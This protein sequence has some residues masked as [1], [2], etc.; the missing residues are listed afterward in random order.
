MFGIIT[1]R[2]GSKG[3]PGKNKKLLLGKPLVEWTFIAASCSVALDKVFLFSDD[4]DIV[5]LSHNYPK[6][7]VIHR[8]DNLSGD[9]TSHFEVMKYIIDQIGSDMKHFVI[10]QPTSPQRT[11][12][13]IDLCV[14]QYHK[15]RLDG[16][17]TY[18]KTDI[19]VE[20]LYNIIADNEGGV[21]IC[22]VK[23]KSTTSRQR[24]DYVYK[25]D[26]AI[27]IQSVKSFITNYGNMPSVSSLNIPSV[28]PYINSSK[29][30]DIDTQDDFD[31]ARDIM[32]SRFPKLPFMIGDREIGSKPFVIVEIGINHE[33][34][35]DKAIKMIDDACDAGAEC[36]KFQCHVIDDEMAGDAKNVIPGNA[37]V[38]IHDIMSR[39]AFNKD[40]ERELME[41]TESKGAI[42]MSTP[43]SRAAANRLESMGVKAY[44]IGSGECNNYPLIEHI[45]KFG[46]PIIISTGMNDISSI[47]PAIDIL[48]KYK[49]PFVINQCTSMYPTPYDMVKLNG[50]KD[51]EYQYPDAHLGLSCHSIGIWSCIGAVPFGATVFEKHFTSDKKWEGPDVPISINPE[52]LS[53]LLVGLDA[54]SK[55]IPGKK[56]ILP[57]EQ[58]TIDFAYA[59]VVSI[60]PIVKGEKLTALNVWVKRPGTGDFL[61]K[62]YDTLIADGHAK[63]DIDDDTVLMKKHISIT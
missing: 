46:K 34:S 11:S 47:S 52:E 26:G 37:T 18:S 60:K 5:K 58:V 21:R 28:Y 33:G 40:Q 35:M 50:L 36:V 1:A 63:V 17:S 10:L 23:E 45:A 13:L 56:E 12:K 32:A 2:K 9:N 16:L 4:E 48:R 42:F 57:E 43:F 8:P 59:S 41:Y 15:S 61:A 25:E 30:V 39:C 20:K 19:H 6:V 24:L 62:E 53:D 29:I 22:E 38:S 7:E 55:C 3:L 49:L 54:V 31:E 44:K 51:I 14:E 27:F